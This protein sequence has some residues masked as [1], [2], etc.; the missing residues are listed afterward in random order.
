MFSRE[1]IKTIIKIPLFLAIGFGI[2]YFV[3]IKQSR[4][5]QQECILKG[6]AAADCN[7]MKKVYTDFIH[8]NVF[9][10]LLVLFMFFLSNVARA[11]RWKMMLQTMDINPKF[12]SAFHSIMLGYFANLGIP[13]IGEFVRAGALAKKEN[14]KFDKVMGTIVLDRLLDFI[15]L[16]IVFLLALYFSYDKIIDFIMANSDLSNKMPTQQQNYYLLAILVLSGGL[17]ILLFRN[18]TFKSSVIGKKITGFIKGLIEGFK[19]IKSIKKPG[20]FIFYSV[21]IWSMYFLMNYFGFKAF[22]ATSGLGLQAAIVILAYGSL[23]IVIPS[24]GGMGTYHFLVTEALRLYGISGSDGFSYANI[25]FILIQIV[26]IVFFGIIALF[27]L[28]RKR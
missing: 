22:H 3:Y 10:L 18:K 5:Y 26:G 25:I 17:V 2:L 6:I 28:N 9:Y 12:S 20:L 19:S 15:S 11:L 13:R 1:N 4:A 16:G 7:L 27:A 21:F 8:S 24:P 23:G 14:T